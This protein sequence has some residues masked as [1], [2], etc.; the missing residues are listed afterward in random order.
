MDP[1]IPATETKVLTTDKRGR[2]LR[3]DAVVLMHRGWEF[4]P[5]YPPTEQTRVRKITNQLKEWAKR[6]FRP[7]AAPNISRDDLL[8]LQQIFPRLR[9]FGGQPQLRLRQ[10][11]DIHQDRIQGWPLGDFLN[12]EEED[13]QRG[14]EPRQ[15]GCPPE[16]M[17]AWRTHPENP[18]RQVGAAQAPAQGTQPTQ[19]AQAAQQPQ[20]TGL[21]QW[22]HTLPSYP[23]GPLS[24]YSGQLNS[25]A[26]ASGAPQH[27][28]GNLPAPTVAFPSPNRGL[29]DASQQ[30]QQHQSPQEEV[31]LLR[32]QTNDSVAPPFNPSYGQDIP[33][34]PELLREPTNHWVRPRYPDSA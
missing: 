12:T 5:Q 14:I 9:R 21:G 27:N 24:N 1:N 8:Y 10:W 6:G 30:Q 16:V 2:P 3:A 18:N 25:A 29:F 33:I 7:S 31:P 17:E 28:F 11:L 20:Q 34:A 32:Q 23:P 19:R 4:R 15:P 22:Q 13:Q 26:A